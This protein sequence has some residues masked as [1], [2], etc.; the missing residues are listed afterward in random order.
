MSSDLISYEKDL[1][2]ELLKSIVIEA[3]DY[4]ERMPLSFETLKLV[5]KLRNEIDV[6]KQ[7]DPFRA[8]DWSPSFELIKYTPAGVSYGLTFDGGDFS[9][10]KITVQNKPSNKER[11]LIFSDKEQLDLLITYL[12]GAR[13]N[14][15]FT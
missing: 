14:L 11:D 15:I 3:A 2:I 6:H 12:I 10:L 5:K 9:S 8:I 7:V 13:N 4:L 1:E